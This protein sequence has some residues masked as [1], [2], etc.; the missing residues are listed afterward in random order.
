MAVTN[1]FTTAGS[2]PNV[3]GVF[4][5]QYADSLQR[6]LNDNNNWKETTNWLLSD[7]QLA[8]FP[9]MATAD[10]PAMRTSVTRGASFTWNGFTLTNDQLRINTLDIMPVFVDYADL[11][12]IGSMANF[13]ALGERMGQIVNNRVGS[14]TLAQHA[15][16]TDFDN[17][18]IGG[19][20]GN[21][22][23]SATN[24]DDIITGVVREI[25]EANGFEL[26]SEKGSF[27]EWRPA[28]KEYLTK[29]AQANGFQLADKALKDGL[30]N[31]YYFMG[32]FHYVS[33]RH[34]AGHL[35]GGV[36]KI[37]QLGLLRGTWGR[38]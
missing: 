15:L 3:G 16:W 27:I 37:M 14:L 25:E 29:F 21:I 28:D 34:T 20:A 1:T 24:V 12:Q 4:P 6:R 8:N 23:V 7:S 26:L 9:Y 19:A 17:A 30:V 11:G 22:T 13:V 38:M 18:S 32:M 35:F 33:N 10:E 2:D 36:R 31:G 5:Q